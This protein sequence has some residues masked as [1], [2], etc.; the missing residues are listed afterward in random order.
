MDAKCI[1]ESK[2]T[3]T[4]TAIEFQEMRNGIYFLRVYSALNEELKEYKIIKNK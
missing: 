2:I 1:A 3:S 4:E